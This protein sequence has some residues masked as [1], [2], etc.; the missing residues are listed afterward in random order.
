MVESLIF[1]YLALFPFGQIIRLGIFHPVDIVAGC[2]L[3]ILLTGKFAEP[4]V[5]GKLRT[6]FIVSLFSLLFSLA[7][8]PLERVIY[9]ALY[10][11]RLAAYASFFAVLWNFCKVN[12]DFKEKLFTGLFGALL[13]VAIF[14]WIQY[15]F[16]PDVRGL[17]EWG[18]D[19]HLFRMV[20]TFLD[21]GFTGI[22]L[23]FGL[24]MALLKY[25]QTKRR[26]YL[27]LILMF[28]LSVAF[29]YS[30]AAYLALIAGVITAAYFYKKFLLGLMFIFAFLVLIFVLPRP[31]GEGVKLERT[32]SVEKRFTNYEEALSLIKTS[33]LFG[34]G[35]NNVCFAK[36]KFL[37]KIDVDSHSCT[38][39]DS[40]LLFILATVGTIGFL[41]FGDLFVGLIR[42]SSHNIYGF[43]F[44][45]SLVAVLI[46]S[47]FIN[48]LF[49]PWVM[50]YLAVVSAT[51][52]T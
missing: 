23:V 49:Y 26:K 41:V 35:F 11:L 34:V 5:F 18:W 9:G 13:F 20:G 32:A 46:D 45:S 2:F 43:L 30:R 52:Q 17:Y 19:D 48:S 38:G 12:T 44:I 36:E 15:F 10:L 22:I 16:F 4:Q 42:N 25:F 39:V 1:A 51:T 21:P 7:I 28:A 27:F 40:S 31:E 37:G 33:P 8:F 50:G 29:T 3:V 6:F 47:L 14:G 24:L